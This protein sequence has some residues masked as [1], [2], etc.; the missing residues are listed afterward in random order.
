MAE[1]EGFEP[2]IRVNVYTLSRRA[3]STTRT[4]LQILKVCLALGKQSEEDSLV[5]GEMQCVYGENLIINRN[6]LQGCPKDNFTDQD[7]SDCPSNSAQ[8][9]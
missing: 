5:C 2:S 4:P 1:R 8:R 3:P 6:D 7:C 9:L